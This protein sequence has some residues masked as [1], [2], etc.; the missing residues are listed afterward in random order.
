MFVKPA[1]GLT[2]RDPDLGG[3]LPATGRDVPNTEYWHRRLFDR[4]VE[5]TTPSPVVEDTHGEP[6]AL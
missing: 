5:I 4:D 3:Y 6:T 1:A 2:I